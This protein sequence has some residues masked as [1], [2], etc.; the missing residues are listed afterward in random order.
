LK[1]SN[2]KHPYGRIEQRT[3][4]DHRRHA[5]GEQDACASQLGALQ[6]IVYVPA[7]TAQIHDAK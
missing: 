5:G 4:H 7:A 2:D 6:F 3:D 1:R